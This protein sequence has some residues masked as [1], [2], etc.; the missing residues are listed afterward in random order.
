MQNVVGH[1]PSHKMQEE[2]EGEEEEEE[3]EPHILAYWDKE[4]FEEAF[5]TMRA[6]IEKLTGLDSIHKVKEKWPECFTMD[7]VT[8]GMRSTQLSES[9]NNELKNHL[10]AYLGILRFFKHLKGL[11]K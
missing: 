7:V 8:L 1:I 11:C 3:D 5:D 10:K 4:T 9:L 2:V 6:K